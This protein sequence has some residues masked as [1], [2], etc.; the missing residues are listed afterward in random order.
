[1][2]DAALPPGGTPVRGPV[3][4]AWQPV[5]IFRRLAHVTVPW[6]VAA[7]WALDLPGSRTQVWNVS[8]NAGLSRGQRHPDPMT[9]NS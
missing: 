1:M 9:S 5:E 8:W 4:A 3:W 2:A 6:Y 7:G